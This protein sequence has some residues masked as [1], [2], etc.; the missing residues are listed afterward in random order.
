MYREIVRKCLEDGKMRNIRE[1]ALETSLET[2][3][4][5]RV[6]CA[7]PREFRLRVY[8]ITNPLESSC[9]YGLAFNCHKK[10]K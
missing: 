6:L 9:Y 1:I 2:I 3:Q 4:V 10:Q 7:H 5:L 8:S